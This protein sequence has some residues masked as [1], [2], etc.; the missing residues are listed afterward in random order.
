MQCN[1]MKWR[2]GS[3]AL[4]THGKNPP[5]SGH[6]TSR[7]SMAPGPRCSP[8]P[9]DGH[10]SSA[11]WARVVSAVANASLRSSVH[12][13]TYIYAFSLDSVSV[14][15]F[16]SSATLILLSMSPLPSHRAQ[17]CCIRIRLLNSSAA[18]A[19]GK[20]PAKNPAQICHGS[21]SNGLGS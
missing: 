19:N 1:A 5:Q 13:Y 8:S 11:V 12:L 3:W 9:G 15:L 16:R 21:I 2:Q 17:R 20:M 6:F 14:P 10:Q 18:I 7:S 4:L